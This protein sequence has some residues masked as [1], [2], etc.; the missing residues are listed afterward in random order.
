MIKII[1]HPLIKHKLSFIR[2]K[3]TKTKEFNESLNEI[4]SL[5]A[6][7]ITR[8]FET[9]KIIIETPIAKTECEILNKDVVLVP[10]LR[11]GLGMLNGIRN[12]IPTAK[13]GFVGVFR[14]EKTLL[15]HEY[16]IKCPELVNSS[17]LVLDP[18]LATGNSAC[19]A[20]TKLKELGAKDIRY[21]GL[22]GC[23]E[24]VKK[25]NSVHPDVDIYLASLD[26]H[27]NESGYI[28]PGLGDCGDRLFG[29]K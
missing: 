23:N 19:Y 16:Y 18:M 8:D 13:I 14:D 15:P 22:V 26:S 17:V 29:T 25:I 1:D 6:Y 21:V 3:N 11:A 28:V 10:I 4:A 27:L 12:L 9:K 7:E 20:I 2:D 5:M 24:G